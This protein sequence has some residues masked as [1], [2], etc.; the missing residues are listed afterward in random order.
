MDIF[1]LYTNLT[2][3]EK[4]AHFAAL[5]ITC[6][7]SIKVS[8]VCNL[9]LRSSFNQKPGIPLHF[10]YLSFVGPVCVVADVQ[11]YHALRRS[12]LADQSTRSGLKTQTKDFGLDWLR[13]DGSYSNTLNYLLKLK[14]H[15]SL[16]KMWLLQLPFTSK[17][18]STS[19]WYHPCKRHEWYV[20]RLFPKDR[21]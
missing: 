7:M 3:T 10:S 21:M 18:C 4:L 17:Q 15:I 20:L 12:R 2:K 19:I 6:Y 9:K 8:F 1:L 14:N 5:I 13:G 11:C 16:S